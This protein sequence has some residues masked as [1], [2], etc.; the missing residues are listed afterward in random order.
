MKI[1]EEKLTRRIKQTDLVAAQFEQDG[2]LVT[3]LTGVHLPEGMIEG[4]P[5]AEFSPVEIGQQ[6]LA[7]TQA[8][9]RQG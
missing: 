4:L 1:L 6:V 9:I 2:V 7:S 3:V 5:T 8:L